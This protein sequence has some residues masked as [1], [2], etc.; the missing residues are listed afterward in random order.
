[1]SI[2]RNYGLV[3]Q[4]KDNKFSAYKSYKVALKETTHT[5]IL[6]AY[7]QHKE[8]WKRT[9]RQNEHIPMFSTW[10]NRRSWEDD[11]RG[12]KKVQYAELEY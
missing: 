6:E 10:L 9:E 1:M 4:E 12:D 8:Y 2:L 3:K 7:K 11:V 5:I